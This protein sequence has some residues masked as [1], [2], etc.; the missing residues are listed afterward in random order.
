MEH[1]LGWVKN[2]P[3]EVIP[4]LG[5]EVGVGVGQASRSSQLSRRDRQRYKP[6]KKHS[7]RDSLTWFIVSWVDGGVFFGRWVGQ[8]GKGQKIEA[9]YLKWYIVLFLALPGSS[10]MANVVL[11]SILA[12]LTL[13]MS[14]SFSL[15]RQI[16]NQC[17][18][19]PITIY[20]ILD[21]L[22]TQSLCFSLLKNG[23]RLGT[24][25]WDYCIIRLKKHNFW[26]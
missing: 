25:S 17:V 21:K 6:M 8:V 26:Y 5:L 1:S 13:H 18:A 23:T 7:N 19:L 15:N 14:L 11:S 2:F 9:L 16:C 3:G 12:I 24:I 20:V 4:L 10:N 22:A